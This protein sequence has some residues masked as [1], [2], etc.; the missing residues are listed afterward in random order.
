MIEI[1]VAEARKELADAVNRVVYSGER[2][3]LK[4]HGRDVAVIISMKE[5]R[6][7]EKAEDNVDIAAA[8]KR[9]KSG[10]KAIPYSEVRREMELE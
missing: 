3:L 8:K 10:G 1:G 2:V 9:L 5:Y 7:L 6:M 4:R